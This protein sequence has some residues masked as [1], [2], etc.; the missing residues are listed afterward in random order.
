[1]ML[2]L[3]EFTVADFQNAYMA[4]DDEFEN[5]LSKS[6]QVLRVKKRW[7]LDELRLQPSLQY[8]VCEQTV[9]NLPCMVV[10]GWVSRSRMWLFALV[11]YARGILAKSLQAQHWWG[12]ALANSENIGM[13]LYNIWFCRRS[14]MGALGRQKIAGCYDGKSSPCASNVP[15]RHHGCRR[16]SGIYPWASCWGWDLFQASCCRFGFGSHLFSLFV[17]TSKWCPLPLPPPISGIE[18]GQ[19]RAASSGVVHMTQEVRPCSFLGNSVWSGIEVFHKLALYVWYIPTF[20]Y[21]MC[22]H[23]IG[24]G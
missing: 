7:A 4:L 5:T 9:L 21:Q 11:S 1:M 16:R 18:D 2:C 17:G 6:K 12:C 13:C 15:K 23:H 19:D 3:G 8:N 22:I 10:Y 20:T 14:H 24:L